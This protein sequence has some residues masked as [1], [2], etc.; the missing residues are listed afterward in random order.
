MQNISIVGDVQGKVFKTCLDRKFLSWKWAQAHSKPNPKVNPRVRVGVNSWENDKR[1]QSET[2]CKTRV[3]SLT[4]REK[5]L[6]LV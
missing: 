2:E 6:K 5:S 4:F 1:W 3:S